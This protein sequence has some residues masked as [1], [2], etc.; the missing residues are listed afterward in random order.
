MARKRMFDRLPAIWKRLDLI[1]GPDGKPKPGF[2]ERFLAVMD[3]G[4]DRS[5]A[6]AKELLSIRSVDGLPDRYL[7]LLP[8]LVGQRW[9]SGKSH[10]W[11][12]RKAASAIRRWS[13][14][15]ADVCL[16]DLIE[17]HG[18]GDW[19]VVDMASTLLVWNRQGR[20]S[21]GDSHLL[22]ADFY[23]PGAFLLRLTDQV[24]F[25]AFLEDFSEIKAAGEVWYFEIAFGATGV[26]EAAWTVQYDDEYDCVNRPLD[27]WNRDLF[28]NWW[29]SGGSESDV[30]RSP[31]LEC[32]TWAFGRWNQDLVLN[33]EGAGGSEIDTESVPVLE[34]STRQYG[35]WNRDLFLNQ[36]PAGGHIT[37]TERDLGLWIGGASGNVDSTI[38]VNR[39]DILVNEGTPP[40][41]ISAEANLIQESAEHVVEAT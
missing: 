28:L 4:F 11:H 15:G 24:N 6:K 35:R 38:R 41:P 26:F 31:A 40:N 8:G 19:T 39:T 33:G 10:D 3:T 25:E 32:S 1:Y 29:P 16:G 27:R 12:R 17:E 21:R 22:K 37:E 7:A 20:L 2:V 36:E 14:R 34:C 30:D 18:G 9:R 5:H 23:H 13:Y